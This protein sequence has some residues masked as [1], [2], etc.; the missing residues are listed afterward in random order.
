[1]YTMQH[2]TCEGRTI[3]MPSIGKTIQECFRFRALHVW[4]LDFEQ[5]HAESNPIIFISQ[6]SIFTSLTLVGSPSLKIM[7]KQPGDG[8]SRVAVRSKKWKL[9][10]AVLLPVACASGL[11]EIWSLGFVQHTC[12][13]NEPQQVQCWLCC[14]ATACFI[15][16]QIDRTTSIFWWKLQ[17]SICFQ[18]QT[19]VCHLLFLFCRLT[20]SHCWC[21]PL[22]NDIILLTTCWYVWLVWIPREFCWWKLH[23][24]GN[25]SVFWR[26]GS[27]LVAAP[28]CSKAWFSIQPSSCAK[29]SPGVGVGNHNVNRENWTATHLVD[30]EIYLGDLECRCLFVWSTAPSLCYL[31]CQARK[32]WSSMMF[33]A[34]KWGV[35]CC[36]R[37]DFSSSNER[38]AVGLR[39]WKHLSKLVPF[40]DLLYLSA[41]FFYSD[42][43]RWSSRKTCISL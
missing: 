14:W 3:S 15:C 41:F 30:I 24:S 40:C 36:A 29:L 42:L 35:P 32:G 20:A 11:T 21:S 12:I 39:R 33:I 1:M 28:C 5:N 13:T 8:N 34:P 16:W 22:A 4:K 23:C 2:D 18:F 37:Q 9:R 10:F 17:G 25:S 19:W 27:A 31:C 38:T 26:I 43:P 6:T 7:R